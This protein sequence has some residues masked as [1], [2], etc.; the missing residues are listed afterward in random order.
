MI[1]HMRIDERMIHGQVASIWVGFLG[2]NRIIVAND[3]APKDEVQIAA[4][5]MACPAGVKLSIL[6]VDKAA[7]NIKDGKYDQDKVFLITRNVPDCKRMIDAGVALPSVNVGNL[8]HAE[9][10]TKIKNSVSLSEDDI[11]IIREILAAAIAVTAQMVPN[12][13]DASIETFLK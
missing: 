3:A 2:C 12:E 6:S 11:C 1:K 5:K 7:A 9:G 4:L 10:F 8:S 13:S